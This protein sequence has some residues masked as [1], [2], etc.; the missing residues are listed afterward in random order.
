MLWSA[1]FFDPIILPD[2]RRLLTLRDAAAYITALPKAEHAANEWQT[3]MVTL[4]LLVAERDGPEMLAR[5]GMMRALNRHARSLRR[6]RD[7][8]GGRSI[9]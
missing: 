6:R 9:D 4:L 2:G 7:K 1:R 5:I 3:A 8:N